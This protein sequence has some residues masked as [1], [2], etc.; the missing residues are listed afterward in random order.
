MYS[1]DI[2]RICKLAKVFSA[3]CHFCCLITTTA[4]IAIYHSMNGRNVT[5]KISDEYFM[6][7]R[8]ITTIP[9][10]GANSEIVANILSRQ[11]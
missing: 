1:I 9:S 6:S 3:R 10:R 11:T 4:I 7:Q 8:F 5:T 2:L